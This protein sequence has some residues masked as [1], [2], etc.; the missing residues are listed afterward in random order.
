[1]R[2]VCGMGEMLGQ[3]PDRATLVARACEQTGLSDFGD[4]WFFANIDA[5]IPA[6]NGEARLSEAGVGSAAD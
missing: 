5:L 2:K 6:L 4:T 3:V 1:M